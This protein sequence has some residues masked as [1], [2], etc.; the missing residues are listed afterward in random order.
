MDVSLI[1]G[2]L[3]PFDVRE[4]LFRSELKTALVLRE[5][6]AEGGQCRERVANVAQ[7]ELDHDWS[8]F[9]RLVNCS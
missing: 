7:S 2:V 6:E 9:F 3:L 4:P 1:I 5:A 8:P